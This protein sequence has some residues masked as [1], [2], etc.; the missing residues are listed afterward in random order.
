MSERE[1]ISPEPRRA[2]V[3]HP[4]TA[5]LFDHEDFE[6]LVR[7]VNRETGFMADQVEIRLHY[8]YGDW[9]EPGWTWVEFILDEAGKAA[10]GGV[11][12]AIMIWGRDWIKKARQRDPATEPI[13]AVIY[14]PAGEILRTV[15]VRPEEG[16]AP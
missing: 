6:A 7:D 11:V 5:H 13:K 14:G 8:L 12:T 10:I 3:F 4:A 2:V 16:R 15:E 1:A 9:A